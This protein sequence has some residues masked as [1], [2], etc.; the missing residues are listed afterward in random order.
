MNVIPFNKRF[1]G[2][3][4]DNKLSEKLLK[5]GSGIINW[6]VKGCLDW[7][8]VGLNPPAKVL[9]STKEYSTEMDMVRIFLEATTEKSDGEHVEATGLYDAYKTWCIDGR[10]D[11]MN[12]TNFGRKMKELGSESK[13]HGSNRRKAYMGIRLLI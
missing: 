11:M 2:S 7:Q 1:T 3:N 12:Q 4:R 8:Q 5:E 6:A 9:L 10:E 13:P